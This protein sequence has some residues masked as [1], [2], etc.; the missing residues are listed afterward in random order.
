[1]SAWGIEQGFVETNPAKSIRLPKPCTAHR[2]LT[3]A[4]AKRLFKVIN[5]LEDERSINPK[6][7]AAIRLLLLTGARKTE[8][9]GLRWTEI[10]WSRARI[11]LAPERTKTGGKIGMRY[12]PLSEPAIQ[13]LKRMPRTHE[14]VFPA[15]RRMA[16]YAKGLQKVWCQVREAA[17]LPGMRV[18]DLRHSFAS[19][20]LAQSANIVVISRALG[21][22]TTRMTER[23]LHTS[24]ADLRH[25]VHNI[26]VG[27]EL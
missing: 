25:L 19:L 24:D 3:A 4:E 16:G 20:A 26:G 10:D 2:C 1:M 12:I 11:V 6:Y 23:Y 5:K 14:F 8:I 13:V 21:H 9:L 17:G 7:G 22:T 27:L 18:H 15:G